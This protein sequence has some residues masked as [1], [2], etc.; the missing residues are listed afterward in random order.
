MDR[1]HIVILGA[2]NS[3]KSSVANMLTGQHTALVSA[4]AGT[5][6]DP[7][8]KVMELPGAGACVIVDTAGFDDATALGAERVAM[9]RNALDGADVAL[10]LVGENPQEESVWRAELKRRGIPSV[11]VANKSDLPGRTAP[12]AAVSV[13]AVSNPAEGRRVLVEA[14][15]RAIP[16]DFGETPLLRSLAGEGDVMVLVMPQDSSAPKGRLI[17]PQVQTIR[18]ALDAGVTPVCTTPGRLPATLAALAAPPRL[19]VTDSQAFREVEPLVPGGTLLTS[20]SVLMAAY[21]GDIDFYAESAKAIDS[22]TEGSRVLIAEACTHA[23]QG[24]DIG[25]KKI[26]ALLRGRIGAGLGIDHVSGRDFPED[27]SG[28][29]LVI[30]CGGCMF[31]RRHQLSRAARCRAAGVPMTNYGIAIAH[32][33]GILP[34]VTW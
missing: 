11:E 4:E 18:A 12:E 15:V 13:S 17:L 20:F 14:I 2:C 21:K 22:L 27:L 5:T 10:L 25:T 33:T 32:L 30:H 31:N 34:R 19:V 28:Y 23:P 16:A 8:R 9:T 24:E 29:D 3:G 7:V 6:T 26:P 1:L